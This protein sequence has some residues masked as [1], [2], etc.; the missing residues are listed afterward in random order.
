MPR[1]PHEARQRVDGVGAECSW[2][3]RAGLCGRYEPTNPQANL[4]LLR[5]VL[6][7]SRATTSTFVLELEKWERALLQCQEPPSE[8]L[9]EATKLMVLLSLCP[10]VLQEHLELN[11]SRLTTYATMRQQAV[12]HIETHLSRAS[13]SASS[14]GAAPM[15]IGSFK[16]AGKGYGKCAGK[17]S[18]SPASEHSAPK[19]EGEC[20]TC[21]RNGHRASECRSGS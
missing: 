20:Y 15:D 12:R 11:M 9:G 2:E 3:V 14:Q 17:G 19:F 13:A 6:Q 18:M 10:K 7:P 1:V 8:S 4:L 16:G 21:G 5:K